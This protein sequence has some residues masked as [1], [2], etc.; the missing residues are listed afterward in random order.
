MELYNGRAKLT[1][2]DNYQLCQIMLP[3]THQFTR[4]HLNNRPFELLIF[5]LTEKS[6][7]HVVSS[8]HFFVKHLSI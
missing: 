5:L 7:F 2:T 8:L 6:D 3:Q 4:P 1:H